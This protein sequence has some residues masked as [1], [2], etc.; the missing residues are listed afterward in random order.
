MVHLTQRTPYARW[1]LISALAVHAGLAILYASES[2]EPAFDFDR[3]YE[4]GS[5]P[6]RPYVD[7]QAEHPIATVAVFRALA[8]LPGG[9]AGFG[10]GVVGL[11][12]I[13]DAIIVCSLLWGWSELA[14]ATFA[15]MLIPVLDLFFN[16][17]DPWSV[18]A[19]TLAMAAWRRGTPRVLG[20]ALAVGGGLKLWP[21]VLA[22]TLFVPPPGGSG[23]GTRFR[24]NGIAAFIATAGALAGCTLLLAGWQGL[25]QVLTFR[26][27]SGWQIESVVGSVIHLSGSAPR[28]ESGSWRIGSTSGP[29][30]IALFVVA[31]PLCVWSSWRGARSDWIGTGWLAAVALLLLL[32]ALFSA[33]YV[34]WL[35]PAA[36]IAWSEG[37][38]YSA[39]LTAL[40][41]VL[42]AVFWS[43]FGAVITSHTPALT[44]VVLRNVGLLAVAV[45]ALARLAQP[46]DRL[47][48]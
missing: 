30:S 12:L 1:L 35:V 5:A 41:V 33:Q 44:L 45:N 18:A 20:I 37:A 27:A 7:H 39:L 25:S 24:K 29:I 40:T 48:R 21:L 46:A 36:A 34:I 23:E 8:R 32:S 3:Y 26:G 17:V 28:F 42:T 10:F 6:G 31:A 22:G 13:A 47:P 11:D 16:R 43:S 9:R 2:P 15:V 19:A 38:R 4:I 14:A